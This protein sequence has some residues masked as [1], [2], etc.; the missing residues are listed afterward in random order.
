MVG[1][2]VPEGFWD[3]AHWGSHWVESLVC[4]PRHTPF[5]PLAACCWGEGFFSF[6]VRDS[7][8]WFSPS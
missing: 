6:G 5:F 7:R 2:K 1:K 4:H 8:V 3:G